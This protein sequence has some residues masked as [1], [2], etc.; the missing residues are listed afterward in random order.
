MGLSVPLIGDLG[1]LPLDLLNQKS[2]ELAPF[3]GVQVYYFLPRPV[4]MVG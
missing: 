1:V 4:Q 2:N 3:V